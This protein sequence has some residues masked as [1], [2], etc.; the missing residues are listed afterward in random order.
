MNSESIRAYC[1]SFPHTKE[2][3]QWGASLCFKV[4]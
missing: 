2:K 1:L 3:L 4:G